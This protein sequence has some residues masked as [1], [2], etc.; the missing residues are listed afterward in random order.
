MH[1]AIQ[2]LNQVDVRF[3]P[4]IGLCT[5]RKLSARSSFDAEALSAMPLF[6]QGKH[7]RPYP[8]NQRLALLRCQMS[9]GDTLQES[10]LWFETI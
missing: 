9:S 7:S 3:R 5:F 2:A 6:Y 10:W 8:A 4:V 1:N